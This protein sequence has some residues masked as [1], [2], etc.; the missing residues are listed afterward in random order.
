VFSQVD[1]FKREIEFY[2]SM[3]VLRELI[4]S[5][6]IRWQLVLVHNQEESTN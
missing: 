3:E 5:V 1:E 2:F 4:A 6:G